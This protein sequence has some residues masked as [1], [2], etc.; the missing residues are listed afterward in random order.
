MNMKEATAKLEEKMETLLG[1][2]NMS[3][4]VLEA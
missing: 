2:R 3:Y 1:F 4:I